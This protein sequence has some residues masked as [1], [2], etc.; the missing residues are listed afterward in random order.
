MS[1]LELHHKIL[2]ID[3]AQ[4]C[5]ANLSVERSASHATIILGGYLF[6]FYDSNEEAN[7][8]FEI[9]ERYIRL[10]NESW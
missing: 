4:V 3:T 6:Y 10:K 9:I 8:D 7:H 5:K 2:G 1:V